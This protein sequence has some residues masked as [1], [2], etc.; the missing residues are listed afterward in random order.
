MFSKE[1]LLKSPKLLKRKRRARLLRFSLYFI[2]AASVIAGL[3]F[4]SFLPFLSINKIIVSGDG[5]GM[6][7][8]EIKKTAEHYLE[9]EYFMLFSRKNSLIFPR[10]EIKEGILKAHPKILSLKI[11]SPDLNTL[12]IAAAARQ[13]AALWCGNEV[14]SD[15]LKECYFVDRE[16]FIFSKAPSFSGDAFFTYYG[17]GIGEPVGARFEEGKFIEIEKFVEGLRS[18]DIRAYAFAKLASDDAEIYF[19]NDTAIPSKII[20]ST[21]EPLSKTLS[22]MEALWKDKKLGSLAGDI[23]VDYIDLRFGNKVYYRLK[24]Q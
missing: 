20:I 11:S 13:S 5:A 21:A 10:D 18:M 9:G 14:V 12:E 1:K 15:S 24:N 19:K 16:G 4:L 6:G 2:L 3:S 22:N 8:D 7:S 17:G 23:S